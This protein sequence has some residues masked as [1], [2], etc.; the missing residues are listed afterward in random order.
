MS[1]PSPLINSAVSALI[2]RQFS[3]N[4]NDELNV[5]SLQ[6][7]N[8]NNN[9]N[10]NNDTD[11]NS[12]IAAAPDDNNNNNNLNNAAS[13]NNAPLIHNS[14]NDDNILDENLRIIKLYRQ[15]TT[16]NIQP[17]PEIEVDESTWISAAVNANNINTTS[18]ACKPQ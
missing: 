16:K 5:F 7:E 4:N 18:H 8:A 2:Q 15:E 9:H 1:H 6:V 13:A 14:I 3:T 11:D 10:T 12:I 17:S